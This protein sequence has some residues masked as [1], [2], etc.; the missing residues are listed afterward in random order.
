MAESDK[1]SRYNIRVKNLGRKSDEENSWLFRNLSIDINSGDR[2]CL[3]GES[4]SG[5]TILLRALVLLDQ[6]DEGEVKY[7]GESI[8]HLDIPRYR[9]EVVYLHQK[10]VIYSGSVEDNFKLPYTL[11]VHS[12]HQYDRSKLVYWLKTFDRNESFFEKEGTNLSGGEKQLVALIRSLQLNPRFLLF[13]EPTASLDSKLTNT[14]ESLV[15][16]WFEE[17]PSERGYLWVTHSDDQ[18]ERVANIRYQFSDGKLA[19]IEVES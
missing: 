17:S 6:F 12:T 9:T 1:T 14:F 19:E 18:A 15:H 16:A 5:K 4:G 3:S 13:D 7:C 2:V 10:P 11:Q 8:R